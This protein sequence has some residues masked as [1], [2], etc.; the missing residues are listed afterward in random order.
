ML[1]INILPKSTLSQVIEN[2]KV[3]RFTSINKL[4]LICHESKT[5]IIKST[6]STLFH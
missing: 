5:I 1:P 6:A 2:T 3:N 4:N